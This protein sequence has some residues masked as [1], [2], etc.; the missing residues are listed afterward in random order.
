MEKYIL[1][2]PKE[3]YWQDIT[4]QEGFEPPEPFG[5]SA[6]EAD[7]FSQLDHCCIVYGFGWKP[8]TDYSIRDSSEGIPNVKIIHFFAQRERA[9]T[10]APARKGDEKI[11]VNFTYC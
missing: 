3:M 8:R 2:V 11:Y 5:S 9:G 6:F 10:Y 4:Q 7:A 1:H